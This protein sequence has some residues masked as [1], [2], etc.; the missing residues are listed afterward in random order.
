M[1]LNLADLPIDRLAEFCRRWDIVRLEIFGSALRD[2]FGPESDMDFLITFA[3]EARHG[4]FDLMDAEE[5]L[6]KML[7]RPIDLIT[8][9]GIER[10]GNWIRREEILSTARLLYAA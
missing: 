10:S 1:K 9:P 6:Q 7:G 8:R 4:L 2:D 5:E 3:P